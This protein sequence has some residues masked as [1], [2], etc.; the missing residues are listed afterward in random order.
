MLDLGFALLGFVALVFFL[1]VPYLLV[2]HTRLKSRVRDLEGKLGSLQ[3][4]EPEPVRQPNQPTATAGPW[5]AE[6][7]EPVAK[8]A[9][10]G[11]E[12]Q[13]S[14]L[15]T[16]PLATVDVTGEAADAD[17]RLS[18][19]KPA[20]EQEQAQ[21]QA[22]R[23][24]V[25]RQDLV[26]LLLQW[27]RENWV[28]V[29]GAASL[30]LAGLFMVQ[31]GVENGLLTPFWRVM[32]ALGFGA[33]LIA[34]GEAIRRRLGDAVEGS[35]Q[36]LPS[37]LAGAGLITLFAALISARV[38][39][40]LMEPGPSFVA[41]CLVSLLALVL[42]WFYGAFLTALGLLGA[43][44]VPFLVGGQSQDAWMLYYY[45]AL[46]AAVGLGVDTVKRWAWIS[47][48]AL[49]APLSASFLLYL[50]G[51][52]EPHFLISVLLIALAAVVLPGR[53]LWPQHGG[54]AVVDL[55][56]TRQKPQI[57]GEP[58]PQAGQAPEAQQ[59]G[60][61]NGTQDN[62]RHYPDFPTRIAAAANCALG[63][64]ALCVAVQGDQSAVIVL[65]L[66]ILVAQLL[67]CTLWMRQAPALFDQALVPALALLA[68]IAYEGL[69]FGPLFREFTAA[70]TRPPETAAPLTL[71]ALV[72]IA[73]IGSGLAYL[74][75]RWSLEAP[76]PQKAA[77]MDRSLIWA[78]GAACFAPALILILEF[79]WRPAAVH[80]VYAWALV[81]L[82]VAAVMTLL[83][84][85]CARGPKGAHRELR[86]A[87]LAIAALTLIAL[88]LFL[89]LAETALTLA[90]A[91][92]VLLVVLIDRKYDLPALVLFVQIGVAV[93]CYRLVLDPGVGWA[94]DRDY[95]DEAWRYVTPL[96]QVGLGYL[97]SLTLLGAGWMLAR[98]QRGKTALI[99]ESAASLI[100]AVFLSVLILRLLPEQM[101][102]SHAGLGL[103][104]TVWSASL[105]NQLQR[106]RMSGRWT[107]VL[108]G[109]LSLGYG[110]AALV[111]I[112]GLIAFA[113]PVL[114][115]HELVRGPLILDSLAAAYLPLAAVFAFGAAR[116][117]HLRRWL[118]IGFAAASSVLGAVY[119]TFEIRRFWQG[120]D[121]SQPGLIDAELYSYTL[122]LL[123]V[124]AGVLMLA[125][126]RRSDLLRRLAMAGVVL[127]IAKVFLVDMSGLSGLTRVF[128]FMGLGLALV[129]L[130]WINRVMN[131]QWEKTQPK[132]DAASQD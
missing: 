33:A 9:Q 117:D 114:S 30:A 119:V 20:Q 34:G 8:A 92:M 83:C 11:K 49:A 65:S 43:S 80:G 61:A 52:G 18:D 55:F 29:A 12:A 75:M 124:S 77:P 94:L 59:A 23:A 86:V 16:E 107:T 70:I 102:D 116:L 41:L 24:F 25:M 85:R 40:Q 58:A 100:G 31:Y 78:L 53:S 113:N 129:G 74:R 76:T 46:I 64:A 122:A 51:A 69:S 109:L 108:R 97:G 37:A 45:F 126:W 7:A 3:S 73:L 17:I 106:M 125:F 84:E 47:V 98:H 132:S 57:H 72:A 27:L 4:T 105:V 2:S 26:D 131:A 81:V 15:A 101:R 130:A 91:V 14:P 66:G 54:A 63:A 128:S 118:R 121:L 82:A 99:L 38:M 19:Q 111:C 36:H 56:V 21:E 89:V 88:A 68:C 62:G 6:K 110:L 95:I 90:L 120:D 5:G 104:A 22:P 96:R 93:I 123:L 60:Q 10:A 79:T 71:W 103:M 39:Y 48:L 44:A 28:L 67:A 87:V 13:P 1:G 42:G 127:T 50:S 115:A 32:A 35:T 112:G